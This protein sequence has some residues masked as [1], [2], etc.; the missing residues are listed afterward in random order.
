MVDNTMFWTFAA[1]S[2]LGAIGVVAHRSIV[3]A[4]LFLLMVF[5]SIAGIFLLNNADFLALAQVLVYAVGLVIIMLF[6]VMFTGDNPF[7]DEQVPKSTYVMFGIVGAYLVA[8]MMRVIGYPFATMRPS[9]GFSTIIA[10]DGSTGLLGELLF[11][12]YALPF[13]LASILLLIA[14]V[15][16]IVLAKKNLEDTPPAFLDKGS[17]LAEE[18]SKALARYDQLKAGEL[19]SELENTPAKPEDSSSNEADAEQEA[20]AVGAQS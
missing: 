8:T 9:P 3:Y 6:A 13:E 18:T 4:A 2:I 5:M 10:T 16:A 17:V 19:R 14:M 11:Q 15:G 12:N 20:E 1:T 7:K